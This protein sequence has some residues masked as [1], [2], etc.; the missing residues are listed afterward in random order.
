MRS[1]VFFT[2]GDQQKGYPETKAALKRES[3][4]DLTREYR[5]G[6]RR[7]SDPMF[8]QNACAFQ[9]LVAAELISR[10]VTQIPNAPFGS[11]EVKANWR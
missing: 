7:C 4:E 6:M 8:G 5:T 1:N 2:S 3:T 9:N 10:G 11:I